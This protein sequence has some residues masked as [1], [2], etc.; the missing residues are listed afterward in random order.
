MLGIIDRFLINLNNKNHKNT[1]Y[2]I[3]RYFIKKQSNK[4]WVYF[5]PKNMNLQILKTFG[6]LPNRYSVLIYG[7]PDSFLSSSPNIVLKV[8][9]KLKRDFTKQYQKLLLANNELSF[10]G[11]SIGNMPTFY[12][13]NKLK[14]KK[15]IS[16]CPTDKLGDGIFKALAADKMQIKNKTIEMGYNAIRYD[17][18]IKGLNPIDNIKNLPK[19]IEIYLAGFDKYLPVYG[20]QRLVEKIKTHNNKCI[21]VRQFNLLGHVMTIIMFGLFG[22]KY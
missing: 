16:L 21:N 4:T 8:F 1:D 6:F 7:L 12:F 9:N 13:A 15:L 10:V 14:C 5:V 20:G 19:N 17:L 22:K 3:T 2:D 18:I 11:I